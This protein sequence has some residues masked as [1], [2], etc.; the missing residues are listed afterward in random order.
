MICIRG[1][2]I[3]T[4]LETLRDDIV[5]YD[6]I[7]SRVGS[8]GICKEEIRVPNSKYAIPGL[9]DIHTH[10]IG[11]VLVNEIATVEDYER[12]KS[13][14]YSHGVTTFIPSTISDSIDRLIKVSKILHEAKSPGIHLEG[15]FLNPKRRG[16]HK[17]LSDRYNNRILE[18]SKL[19]KI[20]R[21]TIAPEIL[22]DNE[23]E[24]LAENFEVSLGHTDADATITREAIGL[25]ATSITHL[26]NAMRE[27]HH[28]DPGII[29]V[30]LTTPI[31]VEIIADLVHVSDIAIKLV[32]MA[33]SDDRVI[34]ITD[35][36]HSAGISNLGSYYLYD[37]EIICNSACY[38]KEGKLVGSNI[39][40]DE[41]IRRVSKFLGIKK[42]ITYSTYSPASLLGID[43]GEIIRGKKAD[44]VVLDENLKVLLTMKE[45]RVVYSSN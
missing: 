10:G 9:I 38:S 3:I 26:F 21:I 36:L 24:E 8:S 12:M 22:K 7:I 35:S 16:A 20:K 25:G 43:A 40:L 34:L 18:I 15:P 17:F 6:N 31:Y 45:G 32:S 13:F 19:F 30:S 11:G 44:L 39:T 14:Y 23:I 4:P 41:G 5:I 1:L 33:K 29:G 42:A 28:R 27:F 37:E 2:E